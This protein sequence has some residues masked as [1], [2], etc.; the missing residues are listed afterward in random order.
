MTKITDDYKG[1]LKAYL[2]KR[3]KTKVTA[4]DCAGWKLIYDQ[5]KSHN[6][7]NHQKAL[8]TTQ[9]T[10]GD[11]GFNISLEVVGTKINERNERKVQQVYLRKLACAYI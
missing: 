11:N 10:T 8:A 2:K 6:Y 5:A 9:A 7:I 4:E 3:R 1:E